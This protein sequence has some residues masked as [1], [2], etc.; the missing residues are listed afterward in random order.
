MAKAR[1]LA[2]LTWLH[3]PQIKRC[4]RNNECKLPPRAHR[5]PDG[6]EYGR[7]G[8][9]HLG[10]GRPKDPGDHFPKKRHEE[11]SRKPDDL[12]GPQVL[13]RNL[14]GHAAGEEDPEHPRL[15]PL[16]LGVPQGLLRRGKKQRVN[17]RK[18]RRGCHAYLDLANRAEAQ[19]GEESPEEEGGFAIKSGV[20][21][22]NGK[23]ELKKE[24]MENARQ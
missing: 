16:H 7:L 1:G 5:T 3:D 15:D 2:V 6:E 9:E 22:S 21:Q 13:G 17:H 19:A 4:V 18:E 12:Q 11:E 10:R 14:E 8:E 23:E 20:H 24:S